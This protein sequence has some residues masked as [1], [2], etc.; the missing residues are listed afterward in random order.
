MHVLPLVLT[1]GVAL[2]LTHMSGQAAEPG[3]FELSVDAIMRGPALTGYAPTDLRW[4]GD[5]RELF[6]ERRVPGEDEPAT[7]VLERGAWERG[8]GVARRLEP[9]QRRLAP[10]ANGRWDRARRRALF[11]D[12]GDIVLIDSV[13]RTRRQITRTSDTESDPRWAAGERQVTF[14]RGNGVFV[15]PLEASAGDLLTQL[16]EAGP[17]RR[18]KPKAGPNRDFLEQDERTL[19]AHVRQ[20]RERRERREREDD[21]AAA[22]L[23]EL[24]KREAL[25]EAV[26]APDGRWLYVL[27]VRKP[28]HARIAQVPDYIRESAYTDML[29]G[30]TKVGDEPETRRVAVVDLVERRYVWVTLE[31]L[32]PPA[33][34]VS[35]A[36][37]PP[38]DADA[39]GTR[40]QAASDAAPPAEPESEV[41][42]GD[43]GAAPAGTAKPMA[44]PLRWSLPVLARVSGAAL[45]T[46]RAAD[47]KDRWLA[48]IDPATG[49][50]RPCDRLHDDAWVRD[51]PDAAGWLPNEREVFFLSERSGFLH[52]YTVDT[53]Q[54]EAEPRALTAGAFELQRAELGPD[55]RAFLVISNESH[56]G[57]RQVYRLPLVGGA[58][59]RLT[60]LPGTQG[61]APSPD[62]RLLAFVGSRANL[63]P[64]VYV[65]AAQPGAPARALTDGTS[66]DWRRYPWT[67]PPVITFTA[68]DGVRVPARLFTPESVGASR[69]SARPGVVFAHGAGYT[70]NAHRYWSTYS[71]EYLFHHLLAARGYVVL[72]VDYRGSAGYGRDWRTAIYRH[73]GGQDLNDVLDAAR[74]LVEHE[75]VDP[76]RIGVYG[77]SYGG[78]LT[79]MAMF[80]APDTFAAG[81]ALRPV[82]DWAHYNHQYTS[83][84]L[85]QPQDDPAPYRR[86]SPIHHAEGLKGALLIAHGMV[87]VNVHF[88]DSVRLAQRLIE[89]RKTN[90]ELAAYPVEDH[91]FEEETSWAD[92]YRRVLGL[93]ERVL[94][95]QAAMT[96]DVPATVPRRARAAWLYGGIP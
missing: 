33:T 43:G 20:M 91:S 18:P 65:S 90:W 86:S 47:N 87:D 73:M 85:D 95:G 69:A 41:T 67:D 89:L 14:V 44:R 39:E 19:L 40:A 24:R 83:N 23:L 16:L 88:Q 8:Q 34:P 59:T 31:G 9:V 26:L 57:E 28:E 29:E 42:P 10:P 50:A 35:I 37:R 79:L 78:F 74:Y 3:R 55:E 82:T 1:L 92:Q 80:T 63:P 7:F 76:A 84:I 70:Q 72:D 71:R 6:F 45:V 81:A 25:Q 60:T 52:L 5:G 77:G 58:R 53:T 49:R 94:V 56:P 48:R 13:A 11:V 30:R 21:E 62:G 36:P 93:F 27:V 38:A 96:S 15:M 51:L 54:A 4:S 22:P 46:V 66:A 75:R 61:L 68:R 64:E 2:P 17:A 12:H 32:E